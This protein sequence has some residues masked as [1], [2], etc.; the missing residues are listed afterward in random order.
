MASTGFYLV[1][2]FDSTQIDRIHGKA[3]KRVGGKSHN[4]TGVK[5][6]SHL[7]DELWFGFIWMNAKGL[8]RQ[9]GG[10]PSRNIAY[11]QGWLKPEVERIA[12]RRRKLL[13][14]A[15][16]ATAISS[17][18]NARVKQ[19]RAAFAG[20]DR[21]SGGL[22]AIE[23]EHLVEEAR[24]SGLEVRIFF[25]TERQ[26][27]PAGLDRSTEVVL[28]TA[29]VFASAVETRTP[30]GIAAL[31]AP[32]KHELTDMLDRAASPLI[33]IA[34]GLQDPGNL[35]TLVRSAE[36]F[37]ATGVI[38]TPGTVSAWN[39][40]ALRSSAGSVFRMPVVT[41]TGAEIM[42]IQ[43]KYGIRLLAAVGTAEKDVL[44]AQDADLRQPT[45]I[46]IGNEGAG[47][48]AEWMEI[49]THRVTIPCPGPVES[50]NAAVAGSLLLYEA[51]RQRSSMAST[52]EAD[53]NVIPQIPGPSRRRPTGATR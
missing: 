50:L 35:G 11:R 39:Q 45:G 3:I 24:R 26:K 23:G 47:L 18:T 31:I 38:T 36:A 53:K 27:T 32:P 15:A 51:S 12:E 7:G 44:A 5:A 48:A 6:V 28:L 21:L 42:E 9:S 43:Q 52:Q 16:M 17:R 49:T 25:H 19:L 46:L 8:G 29:D 33:L 37:G 4:I 34:A 1:D 14:M 10:T 20:Q 2:P 13:R 41:A 22:V 40:K 30:Q